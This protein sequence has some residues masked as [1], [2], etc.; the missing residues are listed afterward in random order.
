M[1]ALSDGGY[2]CRFNTYV[3]TRKGKPQKHVRIPLNCSGRHIQPKPNLGILGSMSDSTIPSRNPLAPASSPSP[4]T[5]RAF[6]LVEL[7][8]VI[9]I[10]ALL[11]GI[12]LPAL[13]KARESA[14]RIQ[15]A[16]NLRQIGFAIRAYASNNRDR[17]HYYPPNYGLWERP[18]GYPLDPLDPFAFWGVA[19][20]PYFSDSATYKGKNAESVLK[21]ARGMFR[22]PSMVQMDPDSSEGGYS[23]PKQPATYGLTLYLT[24]DPSS[25][26]RG[27]SRK[28]VSIRNHSEFI[29][30]SDAAEH[31]LEC[32]DDVLSAMGHPTNLMQW[33]VT[34]PGHAKYATNQSLWEYY[35]HN[36]MCNCLFLDSHVSGIAESNG[37]DVPVH[38]YTGLGNDDVPPPP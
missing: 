27:R 38:Y 18:Q 14:R 13:G 23:D 25:N 37:K 34:A 15:C 1:A 28:M 29:V 7:L 10:I 26:N 22:C 9:G 3:N 2:P 35:R 4:R 11:M 33:R 12:L 6:T 8:V 5:A 21:R 16:S 20:L 36:K 24:V 32:D 30:C 19:Y 31:R 17:F